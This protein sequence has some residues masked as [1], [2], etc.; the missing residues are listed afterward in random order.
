MVKLAHVPA[1][2]LHLHF[3]QMMTNLDHVTVASTCSLVCKSWLRVSRDKLLWRALLARD[4]NKTE[5]TLR[6]AAAGTDVSWIS[7]YRRM[8][9]EVPACLAQTLTAHDDEVLHVAFSHDGKQIS[10]CS[11]DHHVII[12]DYHSDSGRFVKHYR[13]VKLN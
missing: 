10:S 8:V 12:W 6:E 3:P 4:F 9:D 1:P 5:L 13:L 2:M 7:E 11:K